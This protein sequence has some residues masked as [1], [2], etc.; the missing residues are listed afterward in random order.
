M[1]HGQGR[2][3]W[4]TLTA[5]CVEVDVDADADGR[6]SRKRGETEGRAEVKSASSSATDNRVNTNIKEILTEA[7]RAD[8]EQD[9]GEGDEHGPCGARDAV[10]EAFK[11][12]ETA[13]DEPRATPRHSSL[14]YTARP[15]ARKI[16]A[17]VE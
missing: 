14:R 16:G 11:L 5:R 4:T 13:E 10:S 2:E 6:S 15:D 9:D 17:S 8:R 12:L 7:E 1:S 3:G